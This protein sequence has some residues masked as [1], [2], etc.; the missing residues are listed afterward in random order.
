[1]Y[2]LPPGLPRKGVDDAVGELRSNFPDRDLPKLIPMV[3]PNSLDSEGN[4]VPPG[5]AAERVVNVLKNS[6]TT[7]RPGE[8]ASGEQEPL[9]VVVSADIELA[10]LR[11]KPVL[12][13]WSMWQRGE[14]SAYT[15]IG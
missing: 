11:A 10:G 9:G 3:I 13:N 4:P 12:L 15:A 5:V 7:A 14:T 8:S 1:M 2:L 6:R